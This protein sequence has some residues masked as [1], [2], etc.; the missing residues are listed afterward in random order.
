MPCTITGSLAGDH[1]LALEESVGTLEKRLRVLTQVACELAKKVSAK[2][3]REMSEQTRKWVKKHRK[4][5][6]RK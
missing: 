2:D 5:D 4:Q 1:A 6:A 3:L